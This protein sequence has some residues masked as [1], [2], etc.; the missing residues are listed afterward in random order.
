MVLT[1]DKGAVYHLRHP[2]VP[3]AS[4]KEIYR[5]LDAVDSLTRIKSIVTHL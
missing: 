3:E 5:M 1:N 4:H 2:G